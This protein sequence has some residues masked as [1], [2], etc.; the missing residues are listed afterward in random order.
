MGVGAWLLG[1]IGATGGSLLAV[2]QL[3]QGLLGQHTKEISVAIVNAELATSDR[4]SG[5]QP[6]ASRSAAPQASR[7]SG[8]AS[9]S[10]SP[11]HTTQ[12][13][14]VTTNPKKLL[15]SRGGTAIASCRNGSARLWV[16]SPGQGYAV[17]RVDPGPSATASVTFGDSSGRVI[18]LI[19]CN[20]SGAPV[21]RVKSI[22]RGSARHHDR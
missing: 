16:W 20:S 9:A 3:G 11:T 19:S 10:P 8:S 14:P 1:A 4:G 13:V 22:G 12:T 7:S 2:D 21:E 17:V 6:A 18:M 5:Q 15:T